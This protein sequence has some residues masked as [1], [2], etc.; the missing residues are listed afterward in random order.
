[1]TT[2]TDGEMKMNTWKFTKDNATFWDTC[3]IE[4][5]N[6]WISKGWNAVICR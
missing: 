5:V 2:P 4:V 1:M 6:E 3:S